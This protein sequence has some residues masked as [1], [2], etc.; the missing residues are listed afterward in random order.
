MILS[1]IHQLSLDLKG[2]STTLKLSWIQECL[3]HLD[4]MDPTVSQ[5]CAKV[6]RT[7]AKRVD[8]VVVMDSSSTDS[9]QLAIAKSARII[10]MILKGLI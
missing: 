1:I 3:I 9:K 6:L 4:T 7:V 8:E 5:Y 2:K 10:G